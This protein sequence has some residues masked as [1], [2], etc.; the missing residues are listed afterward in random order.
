LTVSD[1]NTLVRQQTKESAAT[2]PDTTLIGYINSGLDD[3]TPVAKMLSQKVGIALTISGG[4]ASIDIS[5]DPDLSTAHEFVNVFLTPT[6]GAEAPLRRLPDSDTV[7]QGWLLTASAIVLQNLTAT[8]GTARVD[9]YRKLAHVSATTDTPALPDQYHNLLVL[10]CC[11]RIQE[12]E[13]VL[14]VKQDFLADYLA[15]KQA[16][17]VQRIWDMEPQN[18][19]IVRQAYILGL[20]GVRQGSRR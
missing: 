20:L 14:A 13:M 12:R 2:Y 18:R 5:S 9:Y 8:G 4:A 15:A 3:L 16:F 19:P 11:A 1:I 6:G 10:Y 17:A 7:S